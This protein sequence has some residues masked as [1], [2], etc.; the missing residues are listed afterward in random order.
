MKSNIRAAL[1]VGA[2]AGIAAIALLTV[3]RSDGIRSRRERRDAERTDRYQLERWDGE[4]GS[5]AE[6]SFAG[7]IAGGGREHA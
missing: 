1:A 7:R 4:G 6:E 2:T 3:L 5:L